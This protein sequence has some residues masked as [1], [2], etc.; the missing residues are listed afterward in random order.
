M[1]EIIPCIN[2]LFVIELF[3][4]EFYWKI[5]IYIKLESIYL[6]KG[7]FLTLLVLYIPFYS[8]LH[9]SRGQLSGLS[10]AL[11]LGVARKPQQQPKRMWYKKN[12]D[13]V[14]Y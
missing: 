8:T 4:H 3:F 9:I 2:D 10:E 12:L 14:Q 5:F 1:A 13:V 6:C 11:L 7:R